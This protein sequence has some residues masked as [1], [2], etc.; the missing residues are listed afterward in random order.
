MSKKNRNRIV[1]F[2]ILLFFIGSQGLFLYHSHNENE[3]EN[4]CEHSGSDSH[5][6]N[7]H[8]D[9]CEIC[10]HNFHSPISYFKLKTLHFYRKDFQEYYFKNNRIILISKT[11]INS[12][13]PP[14]LNF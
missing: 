7:K 5:I 12:R 11:T 10:Q 14:F 8:T 4:T 3:N 13:G 2:L 1:S 6:H 9:K